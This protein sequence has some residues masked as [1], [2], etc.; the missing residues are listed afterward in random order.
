ML[1]TSSSSAGGAGEDAG[2]GIGTG[3]RAGIRHQALADVRGKLFRQPGRDILQDPRTA[4]L[5]QPAAQLDVRSNLDGGVPALRP[6]RVGNRRADA[7]TAAPVHTLAD[8]GPHARSVVALEEALTLEL[9]R[10]GPQARLEPASKSA[11]VQLLGEAGAGDAF[12]DG[13]RVG[14]KR[15]HLFDGPRNEGPLPNLHR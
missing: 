5:R 8:D 4:H 7:R 11:A 14:K 12:G 9:C 3:F 1:P 2:V 10:N 6:N 13:S 15:P